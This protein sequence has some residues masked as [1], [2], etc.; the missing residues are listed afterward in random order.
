MSRAAA[1]RS[2]LQESHLAPSDPGGGQPSGIVR[3]RIDR[4]AA[5]FG[6]RLFDHEMAMDHPDAIIAIGCQEA[7]AAPQKGLD[8][9]LVRRQCRVSTSMGEKQIAGMM[10]NPKPFHEAAMRSKRLDQRATEPRGLALVAK[11][12]DPANPIAH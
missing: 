5:A 10:G 11:A 4:D 8:I 9:L 1:P 3:S 6:C 12:P 7:F 2:G